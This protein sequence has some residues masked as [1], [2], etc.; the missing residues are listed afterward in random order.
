MFRGWH[1]MQARRGDMTPILLSVLADKP[2]HGY[3]IIR[4]LEKKSHGLWRPSPGSVYPT[5]QMLEEEE[6]V[7]AKE[8]GGKKVYTLTDTG[9][10]EAEKVKEKRAHGPWRH[11][12]IDPE[13]MEKIIELKGSFMQTA[14]AFKQIARS[15]EGA[16]IDEAIKVIKE[17]QAKLEKIA[18][19]D[20]AK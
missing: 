17:A 18:A 6:L 16:K 12:D 11:H 4:E 20:P 15:G 3:E 14:G 13:Y 5:L 8:E 1:G 19:G 10:S 7:T 2:M 9:R